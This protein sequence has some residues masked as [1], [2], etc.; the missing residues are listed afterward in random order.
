MHGKERK[1][2]TEVQ[3]TIAPGATSFTVISPV[4]W[5]AGDKIAVAATSYDHYETEEK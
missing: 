1:T 3:T 4:D 5:V 2:W